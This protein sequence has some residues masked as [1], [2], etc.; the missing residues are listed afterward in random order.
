MDSDA[1]T[2]D[3]VYDRNT[4]GA[5]YTYDPNGNMTLDKTKKMKVEYSYLNLPKKVYE[6]DAGTD[7]IL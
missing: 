1:G 5:D 3:G 4:H 2:D 6:N 7:Q